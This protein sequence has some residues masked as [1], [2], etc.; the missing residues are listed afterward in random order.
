MC[1]ALTEL[2]EEGKEEGRKEGR[3]EGRKEGREEGREEGIAEGLRG[4]ILDNLDQGIPQ[5]LI[6]E[7]LCKYIGIS[8]DKAQGYLEKAIKAYT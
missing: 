7:K 6:V 8:R 4:M 1:K 3:E 2:I 5:E